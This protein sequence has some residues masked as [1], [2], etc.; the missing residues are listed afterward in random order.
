MWSATC[1]QFNR[2]HLRGLENLQEF[3]K[4]SEQPAFTEQV[5]DSFRRETGTGCHIR[6]FD[7]LT[8]VLYSGLS[9]RS[10]ASSRMQVKLTTRFCFAMH[11]RDMNAARR[12]ILSRR[13]PRK[14]ILKTRLIHY[15]ALA[16][17]A[18]GVCFAEHNTLAESRAAS[19]N[20]ASKEASTTRTVDSK[21]S[22]E[23]PNDSPSDEE[24]KQTKLL[25]NTHESLAA[26]VSER[27]WTNVGEFEA[28]AYSLNG[29]TASGEM[30]RPGVIAADPRVLPIGTVVHIQAG[31]YSGIYTVLDTGSLVKGKRID[32]YCPSRKQAVRFGRRTVKIRVITAPKSHSARHKQLVARS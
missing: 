18:G 31:V 19:S 8:I 14:T 12:L 25:L 3:H 16:V 6:A 2:Q 13:P 17:I 32:I 26:T 10:H 9:L 27:F 28:S 23:L 20:K 7:R 29:R 24:V 4:T 11:R 21:G 22:S 30:T 5:K 1:C 15:S